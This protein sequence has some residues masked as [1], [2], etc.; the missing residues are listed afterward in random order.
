[1]IGI[2]R[3]S[4]RAGLC[5]LSLLCYSAPTLADKQPELN[6]EIKVALQAKLSEF[7]AQASAPDGGFMVLDRETA[8]LKTLY[9]GALI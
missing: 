7:L 4:L 2:I 9:A 1:M 5:V 6:L 8:E 3:R